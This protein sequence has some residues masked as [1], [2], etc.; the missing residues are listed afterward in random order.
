MK[1]ITSFALYVTVFAISIGCLCY[2]RKS[3]KTNS[4]NLLGITILVLLAAYRYNTGTDFQQY[5]R[6]FYNYYKMSWINI[7]FDRDDGWGLAAVIKV[8][9]GIGGARLSFGICAFLTI[10]PMYISLRNEYSTLPLGISLF[11]YLTTGFVQSFNLVS[12]YISI[13]ILFL[14]FKYI[15]RN[16]F[17]KYLAIVLV[18]FLFHKSALVAIVIYFLWDHRQECVIQGWKR[19]IIILA[20]VIGVYFYQVIIQYLANHTSFFRNYAYFITTEES[21][22]RDFFLSLFQL[23][24]VLLCYPKIKKQDYHNEMLVLMLVI[25]TLIGVTG[26]THPQFKRIAYYFSV[27]STTILIGYMSR[28]PVLY[29]GKRSNCSFFAILYTLFRFVLVYYII[30]SLGFNIRL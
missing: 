18:A 5:S 27:P 25:S 24:V 2:K 10:F 21:R 26:F 9:Y 14:S 23:A 22:N 4:I 15:Y 17:K 6:N 8:F 19:I 16:Q 13:S 28:I 11:W 1:G 20:T 7:L 30:G 3:K 12:Q 29:N